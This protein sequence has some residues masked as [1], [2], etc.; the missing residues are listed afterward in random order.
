M[1]KEDAVRS[2]LAQGLQVAPASVQGDMGGKPVTS[3]CIP[4]TT[5]VVSGENNHAEPLKNNG[6]IHNMFDYVNI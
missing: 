4:F 6:Q 3:A 5:E 1:G 2:P